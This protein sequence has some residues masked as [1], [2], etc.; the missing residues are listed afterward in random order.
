LSVFSIALL[1]TSDDQKKIADDWVACGWGGGGYFWSCAYHPDNSNI[2]FL[3]GD[4]NGMLKSEDKG[5]NWRFI[6][7]GISNYGVYSIAVSKSNPDIIYIAT[8]GGINK[9]VNGGENWVFLE[10]TGKKNLNLTINRPF[11]VRA[12]AINPKNPEIVLV[13]TGD[14]RICTSADGGETWLVTYTSDSFKDLKNNGLSTISSVSISPL[15]ESL[16]FA[17]SRKDGILRSIDSGKTWEKLINSPAMYVA[18]S[19]HDTNVVYASFDKEGLMLSN[20]KGN[21]WSQIKIESLGD[22]VIREIVL[23]PLNPMIINCIAGKS[24]SGFFLKTTDGGNTWHK[25]SQ[26]KK[27]PFANPTLPLEGNN[28]FNSFSSLTNLAISP[29]NPNEMFISANWR[30]CYSSDGG[31][32]WENRDRGADITCCTDLAFSQNKIYATAMDEGLLMSEDNGKNWKQ[33]FP[34]KWAREHSGHQW[35]V[36]VV[37]VNGVDKI[38]ST[39]SAWDSKTPAARLLISD[40]VQLF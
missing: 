3:G 33:L 10:K 9:S 29:S 19:P 8:E 27:N 40:Q 5:N 18:P 22:A 16:I 36:E 15:Q 30:N 21:T 37:T 14:G 23:D 12:I 25:V 35:Q 38:I 6:N 11:S 1:A 31:L 26:M 7:N 4:V 2:I 20:D 32:T 34:L 13:G 24:W 39:L 28:G 17:S